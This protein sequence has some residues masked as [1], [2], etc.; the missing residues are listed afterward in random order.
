MNR[1]NFVRFAEDN[2]LEVVFDSHKHSRP[3]W[4]Q[5][6]CPFC[7][8]NP[9]Y[10]LGFNEKQGYFNCWRC[11]FHRLSEVISA[12]MSVPEHQAWTMITPYLSS[13][14]RV[15]QVK[16]EKEQILAKSKKVSLP[17]GCG[18][19]IQ[20]HKQYLKGRKF[21]PEHLEKLWGLMGTGPVGDYKLRIIVPITFRS[22]LVS[23]QGRDVTDK[24]PLRYKACKSVN[25]VLDHKNCL[26][27]LDLV[28]ADT[29]VV[30]EGVTDVWRLG[31]GAVATFGIRYKDSQVRLMTKFKRRFIFFDSGEEE[32]RKQAYKLAAN[33]S[34]FQGET[35]ILSADRAVDPAELTQDEADGLMKSLIETR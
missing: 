23:Y 20:I 17:M 19:M 24:S 16:D 10:H 29:I 13:G 14:D 1:F 27:G 7:T 25:E 6:K 31:P 3:G 12:L 2:A 4:I 15:L 9:G 22:R 8:G 5:M 35:H 26:Y 21:D 18:P 34:G 32:A 28:P 11:G 33:L 30:V